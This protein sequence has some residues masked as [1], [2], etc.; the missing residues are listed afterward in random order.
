MKKRSTAKI[1]SD[2]SKGKEIEKKIIKALRSPKKTISKKREVGKVKPKAGKKSTSKKITVKAKVK[3]KQKKV[4]KKVIAKVK[5][6]PEQ[7]EKKTSAKIAEKSLPK[8]AKKAEAKKMVGKPAEKVKA[9]IKAEP[10]KVTKKI[11]AKVEKKVSV[12]KVKKIEIKKTVEKP[13]VKLKEKPKKIAKKVVAEKEKKIS[14]KTIKKVET[15]KILEKPERRVKLREKAKERAKKVETKKPIRIPEKKIEAYPPMPFGTLPEE[16]YEN[17]ITLMVVDPVK[18]FTFWE[19]REDT[20]SMYTGDLN[21][22]VYDVTGVD[23]DRMNA[24]SYFDITV[25]ERIGS[26]YIDVNPEKEFVADIG[27]VSPYDILITVARSNKV[28]TPRA[29]ISEEGLLPQK[30]YETGLRV[31]Y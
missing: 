10:A 11:A 7:I 24:N 19:V 12:R 4:A 6:K 1:I 28:S 26:L 22:R 13:K 2:K 17:K 16:Y 31:G 14:P 21:V 20:L 9:K 15:K 30:L 3:E 25:N 18:L 27:I 23:F 5:K 8:V 29:T